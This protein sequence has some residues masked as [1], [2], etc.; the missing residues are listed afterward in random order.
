M[1]NISDQ[2]PNLIYLYEHLLYEMDAEN[3]PSNLLIEDSS[4]PTFNLNKPVPTLL[5]VI[6]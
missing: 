2:Q 4:P 3:N 6:Y 5:P 1:E